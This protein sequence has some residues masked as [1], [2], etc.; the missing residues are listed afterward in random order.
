MKL[1]IT[2]I[3]ILVLGS[4]LYAGNPEKTQQDTTRLKH[5]KK[6][7]IVKKKCTAKDTTR[8][9]AAKKWDCPPCGMG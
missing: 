4:A 3:S 2:T 7:P 9:V 8:K 5:K 6:E 1:S